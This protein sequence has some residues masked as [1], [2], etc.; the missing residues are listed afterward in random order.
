MSLEELGALGEQRRQVGT[1]ALLL[2]LD[3]EANPAGKLAGGVAERLGCLDPMEQLA[4][5][6]ADAARVEAAVPHLGLV[7]GR[8]PEIE[9]CGRLHVIVLDA[10]QGP[11]TLP[12]L[13]DDQRRDTVLAQHR[14]LCA[15]P[16][17]ALLD[18]LGTAVQLRV[19]IG[20]GGN[21]AEVAQ[22]LDPA[23]ESFVAEG[24]EV[25]QLGDWGLTGRHAVMLA[26][27]QT[28]PGRQSTAIGEARS[29]PR[30]V[31]GVRRTMI[32]PSSSGERRRLPSRS[33]IQV[34]PCQL[35]Q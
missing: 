33:R 1:V 21:A 2:A 8:L 20:L 15:R 35:T 22:L 32:C 9:R 3:D 12:H 4:L 11:R 30:G 28:S 31:I 5:V 24:V 25:H 6:V 19:V 7:W 13:P 18:P 17:Q 29:R 34:G 27:Y 14:D 26:A 16:A 10:D 23:V